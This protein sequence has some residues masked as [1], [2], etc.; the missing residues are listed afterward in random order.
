MGT[1][2][3]MIVKAAESLM[4]W[5]TLP[6][7]APSERGASITFKATIK[8]STTDPKFGFASRPHFAA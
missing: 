6:A 2:Y 3:K 4:V 1:H 8:P 5:S 7:G